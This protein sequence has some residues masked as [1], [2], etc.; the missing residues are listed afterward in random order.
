MST[1]QKTILGILAIVIAA[2]GIG[3]CFIF[4]SS[5]PS[6]SPARAGAPALSS[7][8]DSPFGMLPFF[9][10]SEPMTKKS[11][12]PSPEKFDFKPTK[13][14]G[15]KWGRAHYL[16]WLMVQ[17]GKEAVDKKI[18]DWSNSDSILGSYP[19]GFNVV[20]NIA[21]FPARMDGAGEHLE[22][23]SFPVKE[24]EEDY[25]R[26]VRKGVERYDGDGKDDMPGL[27]NPIKYWQVENEPDLKA[28][29]DWE[30][31]AN[32]LKITYEGIK[33][34]CADCQVVIGG[35][36]GDMRGLKEFFEPAV[37]KLGGKYFDIFDY[38]CYGTKGD[39]KKCGAL[40]GEIRKA[41]PD[42][43]FEIWLTETGTWSGS[44]DYPPGLPPQTE[45]DQAKSIVKFYIDPLSRGVKKIFWAWGILEGFGGP[46]NNIFD[47]T[48]FIYDGDGPNDQGF[49]VKKLSYYAYKKM[50]EILEGS[51]WDVQAIIGKNDIH[52]YKFLKNGKPAWVAWNE[53]DSEKEITIEGVRSATVIITESVPDYSSGKAVKDYSTAF[54]TKEITVKD[55]LVKLKINDTPVF[56]ESGP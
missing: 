9:S 41:F 28:K 54:S 23:F 56:I 31:Y 30:G 37:K 39:W 3:G 6:H 16:I 22:N 11:A 5:R 1:R 8:P 50:V 35:M 7:Y 45:K 47:N 40:A 2:A 42:Y 13:D 18:Y 55:S 14:L 49:G 4:N 46:E 36:G 15:I 29:E 26:F 12:P 20:E 34:A 10:F 51:D 52:A 17:P 48:G 43:D 38:H 53:S 32:L 24:A 27:K 19:K 21:A 44:P 25:L 33:S